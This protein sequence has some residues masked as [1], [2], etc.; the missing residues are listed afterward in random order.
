MQVALYYSH[1]V[2]IYMHIYNEPI[3]ATNHLVR[4]PS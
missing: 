4:L 3:P 2:N 1:Y